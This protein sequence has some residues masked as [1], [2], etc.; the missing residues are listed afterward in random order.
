MKAVH[1]YKCKIYFKLKQLYLPIGSFC[2]I[3]GT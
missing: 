1:V 2:L 3:V